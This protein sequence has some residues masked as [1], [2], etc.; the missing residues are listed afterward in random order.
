MKVGICLSKLCLIALLLISNLIYA[1]ENQV[2]LNPGTIS[3]S[4]SLNGYTI[5]KIIVKA[6]DTN[7][8]F[9][10]TVTVEVPEGNNSIDYVLTLEGDN[11]YYLMVEAF[12][13]SDDYIKALIPPQ[14]AIFVP[15]DANVISDI[16][17]SPAIISGNISTGNDVE[18]DIA[19]RLGAWLDIPEF[20]VEPWPHQSESVISKQ[21]VNGTQGIDYTLLVAPQTEYHNVRAQISIDGFNYNINDA[22][23]LTPISGQALVRNYL[24]NYDA[25]TISGHSDLIGVNLSSAEVFGQAPA[26]LPRGTRTSTA[27]LNNGVFSLPVD[28]GTWNLV[29]IFEFPLPNEELKDLTG[30]IY[31]GWPASIQVTENQSAIADFDIT[32]GFMPGQL[33]LSGAN[34]NF[35]QGRIRA[36]GA[37]GGL[38]HSDISPETGKF[39][40][41]LP[42]GDW[43][44]DNRLTMWFDYD[45]DADSFLN[46]LIWHQYRNV[47][48]HLDYQVVITG[49]ETLDTLEL[50]YNTSTV[51]HLFSVAGNGVLS[52][53]TLKVTRLNSVL[54][55][56]EGRGS[57]VETTL[58]Q[59][60][61][62]LL[63]AGSYSVEAFARV[64]GSVTEFGTT[65]INVEGGDSIVIGG[66]NKPILKVSSLAD[67]DT[68]CDEQVE[69][70]GTATDEQGID[71]VY[72]NG[73]SIP[74]T[75]TNN[76]QDPNE[77]SFNYL[78]TLEK[79]Q[80]N[81]IEI[82]VHDIDDSG[83]TRL[84]LKIMQEN[85]TPEPD[86]KTVLIDIKPGSC[87]N[88]VNV[89]SKGVLPVTV[90]GNENI[91]V[92]NINLESISLHG[93]AP[94]R[95]TIKDLGQ[96]WLGLDD[97]SACEDK[98]PD[99]FNDLSLKFKTQEIVAAIKASGIAIT[100]GAIVQLT[101]EGQIEPLVEIQYFAGQD[102]IHIIKK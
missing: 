24:V 25:A 1:Q 54:S 23:V 66:A 17:M 22:N 43:Q 72:I 58:G 41:V 76:L 82:R 6:L 83:E 16:S 2:T 60:M 98:E 52:H 10:G 74:F 100:D 101:L 38:S 15:I 26:P 94:L 8:V 79:G 64:N 35:S 71:A 80:E 11:Q 91:D 33:T 81:N 65:I 70:I 50:N 55:I 99:G 75:T 73:V 63:E 56:A 21:S 68:T 88:P 39:L 19:Y 92:S 47:D 97:N 32:P 44:S 87:K 95:S 61:V 78:F 3:G 45:D 49:G 42:P 9:S 48:N 7:H 12:I 34:S 102:T 59:A 90:F 89:K 28:E 57:P 13:K 40:Y 51:K 37:P 20:E 86:N 4:V 96:P 30:L 14:E 69:I 5:N 93:V 27:T 53:P 84:I 67:G 85:C 29:S 36:S 18:V 31:A 62:T 77:V 46:S